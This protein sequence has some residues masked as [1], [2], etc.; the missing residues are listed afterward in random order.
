MSY[1]NNILIKN[2][3]HAPEERETSGVLAPDP[4]SAAEEILRCYAARAITMLTSCHN[5][6]DERSTYCR[7]SANDCYVALDEACRKMARVAVNRYKKQNSGYRF[8]EVLGELFPDA[9]AYLARAIKSVIA[10]AE[11]LERREPVTIS[12]DQPIAG[13]NGAAPLLIGD[14]FPETNIDKMPESSLIEQDD[15]K[16][17]YASLQKSLN[18]IPAN[19]LNALNRDIQREREREQGVHLLPETAKERQTICRARAALSTLLTRECG[20]DNPFI[21]NLKRQR[22]NRVPRKT[23]PSAWTGE[24]QEKLFR[25]LMQTGWAQRDAVLPDDR[26][27]EALVNEVTTAGTVAPPSP[28]MRAAMRVMDIYTVSHPV[29]S[30]EGAAA[31]YSRAKQSRT[32]GRLEEA[33]SLY[34]SC[35]EAEPSFIE[36]LNNVGNLYSQLGKLREALKVFVQIIEMN[37][38]GDHKYIAATNAA[39]IYLTWYDAGR[40]RERNIEL[41]QQYAKTA[42]EHPTPMRVC[43]LLLALVKDSYYEEAQKLL[44]Q[45]MQCNAAGWSTEKF[46]QTLF[47][48]RD[49]ELISWWS[50]LESEMDKEL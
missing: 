2:A 29:P 6:P 37:P 21:Q 40:N 30:T 13:M 44:D 35:W 50:W 47:Q 43:N 3:R 25:R 10:D 15:K 9:A 27:G 41:A 34:H 14:T 32:A 8:E 7:L 48:I 46:L 31:L 23:Q 33:L 18:S 1:T 11:R 39:D 49:R 28:E 20:D 36:A 45:M 38:P 5:V 17:F 4:V 22:S 42:V 12:L 24:R 26:L 19:Y 16:R